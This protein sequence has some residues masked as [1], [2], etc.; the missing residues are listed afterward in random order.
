[1]TDL[2]GFRGLRD[3]GVYD[4][5]PCERPRRARKILRKLVRVFA[6]VRERML[7]CVCTRASERARQ[8]AIMKSEIQRAGVYPSNLRFL[9][10]ATSAVMSEARFFFLYSN[11]TNVVGKICRRGFISGIYM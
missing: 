10:A 2:P 5:R 1:M 3:A 7:V 9:R 8:V 11:D 6:L 4:R